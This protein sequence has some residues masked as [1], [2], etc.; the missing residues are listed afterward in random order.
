LSIP[1]AVL[2]PWTYMDS[3]SIPETVLKPWTYMDSHCPCLKQS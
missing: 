3:H 2:K 1:E